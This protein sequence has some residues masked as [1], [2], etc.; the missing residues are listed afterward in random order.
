M[1]ASA[2]WAD[3][4]IVSGDEVSGCQ[5]KRH[6]ACSSDCD[7]EPGACRRSRRPGRADA[8]DLPA[9]D[10]STGLA[11]T[12]ALGVAIFGG[13][14]TYVVTWL[15]GVTGDPLAST[16]YVM[17]TNVVVLVAAFACEIRIPR[18]CRRGWIA[19][20]S[21]EGAT[22]RSRPPFFESGSRAKSPN[23]TD[24]DRASH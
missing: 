2:I 3:D 20:S 14:A 11:L 15:V 1:I 13:T 21:D 16:Y 23:S 22:A 18:A 6:D 7:P 5:S 19:K 9:R 17:A 10:C 8:V 24:L 4:R 12:Y